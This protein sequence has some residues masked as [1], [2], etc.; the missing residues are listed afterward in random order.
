MRDL[1][2]RMWAHH[3]RTRPRN[4]TP[5]PRP[6]SISPDLGDYAVIE[7]SLD[8]RDRATPPPCPA[9]SRCPSDGDGP[10][11]RAPCMPSRRVRATCRAGA[12][13]CSGWWTSA[14]T[15]TSSWR[16]TSTP[17]SI[18]MAGL[19]S[20][21]GHPRPLHGC[22][23][24]RPATARVGTWSAIRSAAARHAP[25]DH[26]MAY[27]AAG[28]A[29]GAR[30]CCARSTSPGRDHRP[31]IVAATSRPADPAR[32]RPTRA[33]DWTHEHEPASTGDT[34]RTTD[35][36]AAPPTSTNRRPRP[37]GEGFLDTDL[38]P[39]GP[40]APDRAPPARPQASFAAAAPRRRSR[41]AFPGTRLVIPAG[42]LKQRSN[43]TDYP[44]RAHSAF[45]HL[46]G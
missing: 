5:G 9:R 39:G 26:V 44:F 3:A 17:P 21:G 22:R 24:R 46:T 13:T 31:L 34:I 19:G 23:R 12:T 14:A 25:I 4:G 11:R 37:C 1:G 41:R 45:S 20:R 43:D 38:R 40:S 42:E 30:S 18:H 32:A 2:H 36:R 7:S 6:S 15:A 27:V 33:R 10:D 8:G 28:S 16:A 35:R 29:T